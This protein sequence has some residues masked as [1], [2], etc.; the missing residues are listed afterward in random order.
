MNNDLE[1]TPERKFWNFIR[2]LNHFVG[3]KALGL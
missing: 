1:A 3:I 2:R